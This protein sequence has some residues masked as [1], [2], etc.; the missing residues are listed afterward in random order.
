MRFKEGEIRFDRRCMRAGSLEQEAAECLDPGH[1]RR[2]PVG[3]VGRIGIQAQA[4]HSRGRLAAPR[5]PL[6]KAL[7]H[8]VEEE[9]ALDVGAGA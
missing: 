6:E 8:G 9:P 5:K 1:G 2:E 7:A 3:Q 4:E